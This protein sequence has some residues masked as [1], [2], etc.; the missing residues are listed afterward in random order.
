[1]KLA[2]TKP[3]AAGEVESLDYNS[4]DM[5][6]LA[7]ESDSPVAS[8]T[9]GKYTNAPSRTSDKKTLYV[10]QSV[11]NN[12]MTIA[13]YFHFQNYSLPAIDTIDQTIYNKRHTVALLSIRPSHG[14]NIF[15]IL[16]AANSCA[17][18]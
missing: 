8:Q 2:F 11:Q 12:N 5:S 9:E 10:F 14:L 16:M 7:V 15:F 1:M 4:A 17:F 18:W 3:P 13:E 6:E